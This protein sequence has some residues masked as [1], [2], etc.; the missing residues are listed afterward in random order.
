MSK[1]EM[2]QLQ[3]VLKTSI[4]SSVSLRKKYVVLHATRKHGASNMCL[5]QASERC[6]TCSSRGAHPQRVWQ[7]NLSA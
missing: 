3:S 7:H 6:G 2:Q 1:R 4:T 5:C